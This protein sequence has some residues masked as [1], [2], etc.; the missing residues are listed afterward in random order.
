MAGLPPIAS[1]PFGLRSPETGSIQKRA[2]ELNRMKRPSGDQSAGSLFSLDSRIEVLGRLA[3]RPLST[4]ITVEPRQL[5]HVGTYLVRQRA[6]AAGRKGGPDDS[7][8]CRHRD[9]LGDR[10]RLARQRES[11]EIERSSHQGR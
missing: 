10:V 3:D 9:P 7:G 4:A 6:V 11:R 2:S 8:P 5:A 1:G